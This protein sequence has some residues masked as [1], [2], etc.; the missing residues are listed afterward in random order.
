MGGWIGC[1]RTAAEQTVLASVKTSSF[2][3]ARRVWPF[4]AITS[5]ISPIS[6][7]PLDGRLMGVYAGERLRR[8]EQLAGPTYL[9]NISC[10]G[11]L[12]LR[13]GCWLAVSDLPAMHA[14][15][16]ASYYRRGLQVSKQA[17]R[18]VDEAPLSS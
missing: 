16:R 5:R 11:S 7:I 17:G 2:K 14:R 3:S 9:Q 4:V 18:Q 10:F 12:A 15:G 13:D 6:R 8:E 1:T